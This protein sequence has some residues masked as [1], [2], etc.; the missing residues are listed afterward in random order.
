M[1]FIMRLREVNNKNKEETGNG[2]KVTGA[3]V[4]HFI[5]TN[6]IFPER[7]DLMGFDNVDYEELN[8]NIFVKVR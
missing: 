4:I 1:S 8:G 7:V 2:W 6:C 5:I 3:R